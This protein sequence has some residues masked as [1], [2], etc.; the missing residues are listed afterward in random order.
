Q[1][2]PPFQVDRLWAMFTQGVALGWRVVAHFG[3]AEKPPWSSSATGRP[4]LLVGPTTDV[5]LVGVI[6]SLDPACTKTES[7]PATEAQT[8]ASTNAVVRVP[9]SSIPTVPW[10]NELVCRS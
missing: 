6:G 10:N 5:N 9:C 4:Q 3:A 8:V 2:V 7:A 1:K